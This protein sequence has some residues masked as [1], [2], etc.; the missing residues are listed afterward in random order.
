MSIQMLTNFITKYS[1]SVVF[2][3]HDD[4][5]IHM[6]CQLNGCLHCLQVSLQDAIDHASIT[7]LNNV[8]YLAI[9]NNVKGVI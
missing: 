7:M 8:K 9:F 5:V 3:I 4:N 1:W 6:V 2:M